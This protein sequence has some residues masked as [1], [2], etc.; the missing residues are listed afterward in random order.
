MNS[1]FVS[2]YKM[3]NTL[4]EGGYRIFDD[5]KNCDLLAIDDL[6]AGHDTDFTINKLYELLNERLGKWTIITCNLYLDEI[7]KQMDTRIS[8]RFIRSG[9]VVVNMETE[10]YNLRN[11]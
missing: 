8:S 10:D 2:W 9:S 5:L 7:G 4:R 3:A 11:L 1:I 6:G